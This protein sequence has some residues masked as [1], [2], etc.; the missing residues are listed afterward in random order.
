MGVGNSGTGLVDITG[1]TFATTGTSG[2][3]IGQTS[4]A[5]GTLIVNGP[6]ALVTIAST[7]S[8]IG[9]GKGGNGTLEV[10]GGGKVLI[11]AGGLGVGNTAGAN[12][13]VTVTGAGSQIVLNGTG[14]SA[15]VGQG[16]TGQVTVL[17]GGLLQINNGQ[18]LDLGGY[19]SGPLSN[20]QGTVLVQGGGSIEAA[21]NVVVWSGSMLTVDGS[22]GIDI[23]TLGL[24]APGDI[25]VESGHSL[26]GNGFVN[27]AVLNNGTIDARNTITTGT[28]EFT[29]NISGVGFETIETDGVLRLDG[30][31]AS[32]QA[33]Q[34]GNGGVLLLASGATSY[35]MGIQSLNIGDRIEFGAGQ[36]VTGASYN[37][38]TITAITTTGSILLTNASFASGSPTS[39]STGVEFELGLPLHSGQRELG[40]LGRQ[41]QR[42][43]GHRS[44]NRFQLEHGHRAIEH[45]GR[46]FLQQHWI[47]WHA[48]GHGERDPG[49]FRRNRR[50]LAFE[51]CNAD[52][53]GTAKPTIYAV[54]GGISF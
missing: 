10:E 37:A 38:G 47:Y 39:F 50:R 26:I 32:T 13:T 16:G 23:G 17:S 2:I 46:P 43:I 11:G 40:E 36:V 29:G 14:H 21:G 45:G 15:T 19:Q 27:A 30:S 22:S 35:S 24:F 20:T 18:N 44:G 34:F 42:R 53:G 28:L 41:R 49:L 52:A 5:S 9:V 3:G 48:D 31:V 54:R 33:I 12:G 25:M 7:G 1:G 8:G 51:R 6:S 4:G